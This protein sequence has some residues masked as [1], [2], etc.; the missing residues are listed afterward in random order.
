MT[1]YE[2]SVERL[3]Y[4]VE[5]LE[6]QGKPRLAALHL[7]S[8]LQYP[9]RYECE[10]VKMESKPELCRREGTDWSRAAFP[11]YCRNTELLTRLKAANLLLDEVER[12]QDYRGGEKEDMIALVKECIHLATRLLSPLFVHTSLSFSKAISDDYIRDTASPTFDPA[13]PKRCRMDEGDDGVAL[14]AEKTCRPA[15]LATTQS[16]DRWDQTE[17]EYFFNPADISVLAWRREPFALRWDI[18]FASKGQ[19]TGSDEH[20]DLYHASDCPCPHRGNAAVTA[21]M[22]RSAHVPFTVLL[23]ALLALSRLFRLQGLYTPA[24]DVLHRAQAKYKQAFQ[25]TQWIKEK[26]RLQHLLA[27]RRVQRPAPP[28]ADEADTIRSPLLETALYFVWGYEKHCAQLSLSCEYCQVLLLILKRCSTSLGTLGRHHV[29]GTSFLGLGAA[30]LKRE[31]EK[32]ACICLLKWHSSTALDTVK[33]LKSNF[34]GGWFALM[35]LGALDTSSLH[36]SSGNGAASTEAVRCCSRAEQHSSPALWHEVTPID[37]AFSEGGALEGVC[38]CLSDGKQVSLCYAVQDREP[39]ARCTWEGLF[40]PLRGI[41]DPCCLSSW[42]L[43]TTDEKRGVRGVVGQMPFDMFAVVQELGFLHS[44][45]TILQLSRK[46]LNEEENTVPL[47]SP[48]TPTAPPRKKRCRVETTVA[49]SHTLARCEDVGTGWWFSPCEVHGDV[50]EFSLLR[51]LF[52]MS[53]FGYISTAISSQRSE[54]A[55]HVGDVD[56][57][58]CSTDGCAGS[59]RWTRREWRSIW[60]KYADFVQSCHCRARSRGA[61]GGACTASYRKFSVVLDLYSD[62]LRCI[63]REMVDAPSC[64]QAG[65]EK[66]R[67]PMRDISQEVA[68]TCISSDTSANTRSVLLFS[69]VPRSNGSV[70]HVPHLSLVSSL[71]SLKAAVHVHMAA[72]A[73][74]THHPIECVQCLVEWRH[75]VHIF[76]SHLTPI[77]AHGHVL[78]AVLAMQMGLVDIPHRLHQ[79]ASEIRRE[80]HTAGLSLL[81]ALRSRFLSQASSRAA[82]KEYAAATILVSEEERDVAQLVGVPYYHLLAAEMIALGAGRLGGS[83]S[84]S[85]SSP[86]FILRL[87]LM[88]L[89]AIY[90]TSST[91]ARLTLYGSAGPGSSVDSRP[92]TPLSMSSGYVHVSAHADYAVQKRCQEIFCTKVRALLENLEAAQEDTMGRDNVTATSVLYSRISAGQGVQQ[93]NETSALRSSPAIAKEAWTCSNRCLLYL[94]YGLYACSEEHDPY[95]A[96]AQFRKAMREL[97]ITQGRSEQSCG[98]SPNEEWGASAAALYW[99]SDIAERLRHILPEDEED[100]SETDVD[101]AWEAAFFRMACT[102]V[103]ASFFSGCKEEYMPQAHRAPSVNAHDMTFEAD[104]GGAQRRLLRRW[105]SRVFQLCGGNEVAAQMEEGFSSPVSLSMLH[106][107]MSY[108]PAVEEYK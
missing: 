17:N 65:A 30:S 27:A 86:S 67:I 69:C 50:S 28:R 35:H 32:D 104:E 42:C 11:P 64:I 87:Q 106:T 99:Y 70:Y 33:W 58:P 21:S 75:C 66:K 105:R 62:L 61:Q 81:D 12:Y 79:G 1:L 71:L 92:G 44:Y 53:D 3:W 63:D 45:A 10:G 36:A 18:A 101:A 93:T 19:S 15:I 8:C 4:L 25:T 83:E 5:E 41:L 20:I 56:E 9:E 38:V 51:R 88:K 52:S 95:L 48:S 24:L 100:C 60:S 80:E 55:P 29:G 82:V 14:I 7:I 72:T 46:C 108:L 2:R 90:I 54:A 34:H 103:S 94:I 31:K 26:G 91:R 6:R 39:P 89:F 68:P 47:H 85:M 23:Q 84:L 77:R 16:G 13:R 49:A 102:G 74:E 73:L 107:V 57:S 76:P 96:R 37:H 78:I 40:M 97:S 59:Y 43:H 98:D 22:P